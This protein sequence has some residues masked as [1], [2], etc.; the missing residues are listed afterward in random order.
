MQTHLDE[1]GSGAQPTELGY[2]FGE[3]AKVSW[4]HKSS[5][6]ELVGK[7]G[8]AA[9]SAS[10]ILPKFDSGKD[11]QNSD[12]SCLTLL[13]QNKWPRN[14]FCTLSI[15]MITSIMVLIIRILYC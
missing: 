13:S 2:D 7:G 11:Q 1:L 3:S 4:S 12:S 5:W 10:L 6:K 9:F 15:P 14:P 8:N